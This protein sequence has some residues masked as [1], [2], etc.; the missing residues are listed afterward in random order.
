MRPAKFAGCSRRRSIPLFVE[1][2]DATNSGRIFATDSEFHV[3]TKHYADCHAHWASRRFTGGARR[4][5]QELPS[6]Y[7]MSCTHAVGGVMTSAMSIAAFFQESTAPVEKLPASARRKFIPEGARRRLPNDARQRSVARIGRRCERHRS[8]IAERELETR[9]GLVVTNFS[10]TSATSP[11]RA[12]A[13]LAPAQARPPLNARPRQRRAAT[14]T[15]SS[16][17]RLCSRRSTSGTVTSPTS[18]SPGPKNPLQP[19]PRAPPA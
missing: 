3:V 14:A 6:D 18:L 16:R 19:D 11:A 17:H 13:D 2:D 5:G 12:S 9:R 4:A 8:K 10:Q 15:S 1:T 7:S